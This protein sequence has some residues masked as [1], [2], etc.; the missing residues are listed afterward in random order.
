MITKLDLRYR[1]PIRYDDMIEVRSRVVGG[2]KIK[3]RHEYDLALVERL[4]G[5]P[6]PADPATPADGVCAIGSTELACVDATGRPRA[7][8]DWLATT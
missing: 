8:P 3:I 6:D 5:A 7:L 1:R 2:S 4:G